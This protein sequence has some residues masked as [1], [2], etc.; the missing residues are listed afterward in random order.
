MPPYEV[1]FFSGLHQ[2]NLY[3]GSVFICNTI[4]INLIKQ[5]KGSV[6]IMSR[7]SQNQQA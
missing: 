7:P 5:S 1:H 2:F 6:E 3:L 4:K